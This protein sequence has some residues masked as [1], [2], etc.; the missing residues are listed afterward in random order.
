[1]EFMKLKSL[2]RTID[3]KIKPILKLG[4]LKNSRV[5]IQISLVWVK[6]KKL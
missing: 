4:C 2:L 6:L 1:M 5:A 3:S